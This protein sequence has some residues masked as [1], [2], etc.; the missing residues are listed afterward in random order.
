[1]IQKQFNEDEGDGI[2]LDDHVNGVSLTKLGKKNAIKLQESGQYPKGPKAKDCGNCGEAMD[3]RTTGMMQRPRKNGLYYYHKNHNRS[4]QK[5]DI[6]I[7]VAVKVSNGKRCHNPRCSGVNP[8]FTWD[9]NQK[10]YCSESCCDG[11]QEWQNEVTPLKLSPSHISYTNYSKGRGRFS[12][13]FDTC[14][15]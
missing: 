13:F 11:Y 9:K 6:S 4:C 5:E 8:T 14:S 15:N 7:P 3:W 1:L 12:Y 10:L 2:A